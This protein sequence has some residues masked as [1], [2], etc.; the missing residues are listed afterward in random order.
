[1]N[2]YS[3]LAQAVVEGDHE[4]AAVLTRQALEQKASPEEI[5]KAGLQASMIEV[6]RRFS[7][8]ELFVPDMLFAARA[9][10]MAMEVLR[11][12]LADSRVGT[13]GKAAIG[14]VAGDI[15]DI[16]KNLV[17]MFLQGA[18]FEVMDVG[19]DVSAERFVTLVEQQRPDILGMSA[20]L[21]TTMPAMQ[22]TIKALERAELR[23]RVKVVVG[24]AP[25]TQR[26]ANQIG[27]DGYAPDGGA[28]IDLCR[29]LVG[30]RDPAVQQE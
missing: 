29:R 13:I 12:R 27:A 20:L 7:A 19:T 22:A 14:T 25:V 6:G 11:P 1:M 28:A 23:T 4:K 10:S 24:G 9:A 18:G 5:V 17:V 21:T 3:A 2:P 16:G 15:H 26:F 30:E 8:G